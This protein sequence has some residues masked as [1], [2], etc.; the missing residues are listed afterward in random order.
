MSLA[1]DTPLL[2]RVVRLRQL[3]AR[4]DSPPPAC[5]L[6]RPGE[7]CWFCAPW[8][9][10]NRITTT[11]TTGETHMGRYAPNVD[12]GAAGRAAFE[13]ALHIGYCL[14]AARALQRQAERDARHGERAAATAER[15]VR[16]PEGSATL[17]AG[18]GL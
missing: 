3:L 13:R 6:C 15:V 8:H 10:S 16:L 1:T 14:P 9:R 11:T 7:A 18:G 12:R 17:P 2:Q 5:S 4:M